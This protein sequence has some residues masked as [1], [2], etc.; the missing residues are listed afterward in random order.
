VGSRIDPTTLRDIRRRRRE[1]A[2]SNPGDT[3][4]ELDGSS[5]SLDVH[6]A[7]FV[8]QFVITNPSDASFTLTEIAPDGR[9]GVL[10]EGSEW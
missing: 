6:I 3:V 8:Y 2:V 5:K 7:G 9:W 4:I 10:A 1:L